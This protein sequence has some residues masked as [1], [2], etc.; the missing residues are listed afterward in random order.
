MPT[1]PNHQR[2]SA[3]PTIQPRLS[4]LWGTHHPVPGYPA[5]QRAKLLR[6]PPCQFG[7]L[8]RVWPQR[9]RDQGIGQ[10]ASGSRNTGH[11]HP[12]GGDSATPWP[13][14][15]VGIRRPSEGETALSFDEVA[16]AVRS[17]LLD[18][19]TE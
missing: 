18:S 12:A 3:L 19:D 10:S 13:G 4:A 15:S 11:Q 9:G 16:F 7:Y 14:Q 1:L 8:G 5:D 17:G 6:A 2:G